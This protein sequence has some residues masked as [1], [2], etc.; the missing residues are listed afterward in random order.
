MRLGNAGDGTFGVFA[1]PTRMFSRAVPI[2]TPGGILV[3][4]VT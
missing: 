2:A 3:L 1:L 4:S